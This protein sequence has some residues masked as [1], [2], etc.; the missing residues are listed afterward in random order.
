MFGRLC[1]S[2][3]KAK[4]LLKGFPDPPKNEKNLLIG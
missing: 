4:P 3:L 2:V 1:L